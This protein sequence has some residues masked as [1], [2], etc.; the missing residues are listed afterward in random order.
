MSIQPRLENFQG[1][2]AILV[3]GTLVLALHHKARGE[4]GNPHRGIGLVDVLPACAARAV[5][6][7]LQIIGIDCHLDIALCIGIHKHGRKRRV[8]AAVGIVRRNPHQSVDAGF[9]FEIAKR[10]LALH[11]NR[12][13]LNP[14]DLAG[15]G[16]QNARLK[17]APLGPARVHPH[18]HLRPIRGFRAPCARVDG[19]NRVVAILGIAQ[20][21]LQFERVQ[22]PPH[23]GQLGGDFGQ[24][25][26]I[27]FFAREFKQHVQIP[28]LPIQFLPA[29]D[30]VLLGI[31]GVDD[32]LR[33][34]P[35]VPKIRH[36]HPLFKFGDFCAALHHVKDTSRAHPRARDDR[37]RCLATRVPEFLRP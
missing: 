19:Q 23:L 4:V 26:G 11:L 24:G 29:V 36:A 20:H 25:L 5:R 8:P 30:P 34:F 6:I 1:R 33:G 32:L 16:V 9:G 15:Q 17:P 13:A 2:V 22:C 27:A 10:V 14:H 12:R 7:H 37:T 18:Q 31:A 21:I 35:V 28:D 3:L